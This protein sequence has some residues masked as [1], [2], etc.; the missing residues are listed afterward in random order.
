MNHSEYRGF[1]NGVLLYIHTFIYILFF[2]LLLVIVTMPIAER[3]QQHLKKKMSKLNGDD[4][5]HRYNWKCDDLKT[6]L[7]FI[8][9]IEFPPFSVQ[10]KRFVN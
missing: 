2:L 4:I 6:T 8:H 10:I 5:F 7:V 1:I 9:N 3:K